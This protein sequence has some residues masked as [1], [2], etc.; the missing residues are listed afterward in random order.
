MRAFIIGSGPSLNRTPLDRLIGEVTYAFNKIYLIFG[1]TKWRPTYWVIADL[2][3]SDYWPM[4]EVFRHG[5]HYI[6]RDDFRDTTGQHLNAASADY[7]WI[8]RCDK[9]DHLNCQGEGIPKSWHLP[10]YCRFG[11]G[12]FIAIQHA[13]THGYNPLYLLGADLYHENPPENGVWLDTNHFDPGYGLKMPKKYGSYNRFNQT[14]ILAH[15]N[16]LEGCHERGVEIYN[17]TIG[18][19]LEIY[20]RVELE[21]VLAQKP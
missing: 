13:V 9:H 15:R 5:S 7:E 10:S 14:L 11:G 1:K 4:T 20:P 12:M 8:P 19:D 2:S 6:L 21:D 17:A 16:A 3:A 18:G